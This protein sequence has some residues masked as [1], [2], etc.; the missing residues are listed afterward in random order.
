[1]KFKRAIIFAAVFASV[2]G[3]R[4]EAQSNSASAPGWNGPQPQPGSITPFSDGGEDLRPSMAVPTGQGGD[5]RPQ[6]GQGAP[7]MMGPVPAQTTPMMN[8]APAKM[9]KHNGGVVGA[10][11]GLP[12]RTA[13]TGVGMT[14]RTAKTGVGMVDRTA[15]TGAGLTDRAVKTTV[16]APIKATKEVLKA[17]F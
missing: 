13:K 4:C 5:L 8:G 6:M 2:A 1:M 3:I 10:A 11:V 14:D 9:K 15:K 16:G 12:D 17:L 7:M